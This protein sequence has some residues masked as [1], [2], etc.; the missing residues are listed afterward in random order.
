MSTATTL[1]VAGSIFP[2]A[3]EC[4]IVDSIKTISTPFSNCLYFRCASTMSVTTSGIGPSSLTEPANTN[5]T[6]LTMHSYITP[7]LRTLF[8]TIAFKDPALKTS[9]IANM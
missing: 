3:I 1:T 7:V 4:N 8:P 9:L 6:L 2:T 5:G